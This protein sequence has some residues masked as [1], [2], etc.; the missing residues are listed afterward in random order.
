MHTHV[1]MVYICGVFKIMMKSM[2]G[3]CEIYIYLLPLQFPYM[4]VQWSGR[5]HGAVIKS[6]VK[7]DQTKR[8]HFTPFNFVVSRMFFFSCCCRQWHFSNVV[9]KAHQSEHLLQ[10]YALFFVC[11]PLIVVFDKMQF[12][13]FCHTNTADHK[14]V[15]FR[16]V[17]RKKSRHTVCR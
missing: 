16:I 14:I 6:I 1:I 9:V 12:F 17:I 2:K 7:I 4:A 13:N 8:T 3:W 5:T 10:I 11:R 15:P